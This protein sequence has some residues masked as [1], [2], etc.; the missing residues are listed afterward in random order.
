MIGPAAGARGA[1]PGRAEA[2][3]AAE[4]R[5][6]EQLGGLRRFR[7]FQDV[8]SYVDRLVASEWWDDTFPRA[9]SEVELQR[10]S[11]RARASLATVDAGVGV[12]A[13]VDSHGWTLDV[14]LHE[15]AHLAVGPERGHS[16]HFHGAL[17]QLWRHEVGVEAAEVLRCEL[18]A[19]SQPLPT[20]PCPDAG[21]TAERRDGVQHAGCPPPG[22]RP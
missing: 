17:V 19:D 2:T 22:P 1:A 4:R 9:P 6:V 21:V 14:V 3:Y 16:G 11:H 8:V 20:T 15:L 7:R 10:R 12:M 5:S 13:L 18:A